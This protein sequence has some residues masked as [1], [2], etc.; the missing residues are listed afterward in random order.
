MN[1]P[2]N[3]KRSKKLLPISVGEEDR[4]AVVPALG[5]IVRDANG[6]GT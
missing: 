3:R 2:G 4:L 5:E 1:N 6:N